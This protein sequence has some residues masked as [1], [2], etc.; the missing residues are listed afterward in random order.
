MSYLD[1]DRLNKLLYA[2]RNYD[3][4]FIGK[5]ITIELANIIEHLLQR[6]SKLEDSKL[7]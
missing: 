3:D 5:Y 7:E 1:D 2:A 6:I 4:I